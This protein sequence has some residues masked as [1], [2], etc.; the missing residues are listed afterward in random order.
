MAEHSL[1]FFATREPWPA[2][3]LPKHLVLA[4]V[5]D[6]MPAASRIVALD[7]ITKHLPPLLV[8]DLFARIGEAPAPGTG[9]HLLSLLDQAVATNPSSLTRAQARSLAVCVPA[10]TIPQ[11]L[12][13]LARLPALSSA[14]E[15]FAAALEFRRSLVSHFA[16]P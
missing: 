8:L 10:G 14:A 11:R 5:L 3:A 2:T 4:N 7:S 15:E 1:E 6:A 12:D 13:A 16:T 9:K